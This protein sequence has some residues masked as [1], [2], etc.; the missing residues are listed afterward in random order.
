M[1]QPSALRL[2]SAKTPNLELQKD[3]LLRAIDSLAKH[4]E[5]IQERLIHFPITEENLRTSL[6]EEILADIVQL[7][8]FR[9]RVQNATSLE[10]LR[11][12]ADKLKTHRKETIEENIR[13]QMVV[14]Q[15][16]LFEQR[17]LETATARAI[18]I[19]G[20]LPD[21][22]ELNTLLAN[23]NSKITETSLLLETLK[24]DVRTEE[25]D[26]A[27][28]NEVRNTLKTATNTMR[29]VYKIFRAITNSSSPR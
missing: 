20:T 5:L 13:K 24:K 21:T 22:A 25:V 4:A 3:V 7:E 29:E 23:A 27:A 17:V 11:G 18:L 8:D 9:L 10:E 12:L 2:G 15:I 26:D 28:M 1:E 19:Q 6:D 14:A 16:E